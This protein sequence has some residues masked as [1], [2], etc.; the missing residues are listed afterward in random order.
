MHRALRIR[1]LFSALTLA[2]AASPRLAANYDILADALSEQ[3]RV[4]S[5]DGWLRAGLRGRA[6][7]SLYAEREAA[8]DLRYSEDRRLFAP[9]GRLFGE[10]Q[11]GE[12][13]YG[14]VQLRADRGFDPGQASIETRVDEFALRLST[15]ASDG[16]RVSLQA[17]RFATVFG[18]WTR[19]HLA[20]EY[21]F[22]TAPLAHENLVGLWDSKGAPTPSKPAAWAHI[23]PSGDSAAVVS[24]ERKRIP[25]IWGPSYATGSA[26]VI[27]D[28]TREA[29]LE[30]KNAGLSS[31]PST[32]DDID[33]ELWQTPALAA[34]I[35]WRPTLGCDIGI[36]A[37]R[38]C[39]LS[40]SPVSV[41]IGHERD[42]YQ[43]TTLGADLA[44]EWH[45]LLIWTEFVAARFAVP[46]A[47][48]ADT[49]AATIEARYKFDVR[50]AAAVRL[51]WQTFRDIETPS[52][53][54]AWGRDVWR[55]E[56]GPIIRLAAQ[57]QLKF[58]ASLRHETPSATTWNPGVSSQLSLRF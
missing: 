45:H 17:G 52:G 57:A 1:C 12:S 8:A 10:A 9:V 37:A 16:L 47:G 44:Y 14:F 38:G 29:A 51:D 28:E 36:S 39:Y 54:T 53:E 35:G 42:D 31:R 46:G 5:P 33:S 24:D 18:G 4:S 55:I 48:D 49:L 26:I 15:P 19:R 22:A 3:L 50:L 56:A 43:Q 58:F 41:M 30:I 32:W 40:P 7:F 6:D 11:A 23:T 20:W 2:A 34:R 21:P 13:L 27:G 25:V